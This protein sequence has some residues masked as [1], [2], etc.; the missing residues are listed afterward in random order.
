[1][2]SVKTL[3][4]KLLF[5][6]QRKLNVGEEDLIIWS[7]FRKLVV[8]LVGSD[9]PQFS[10]ELMSLVKDKDID[11]LLS[12]VATK[13][14]PHMHGSASSYWR[15]ATLASFLSKFPFRNVPN[16]DPMG[17]AKERS[18]QAERLCRLTNKRLSHYRGKEYRLIQKRRYV[19]E[20]LHLA[21]IKI[22]NWL[23]EASVGQVASKARHGPGGCLGV[24]RP[25]TTAYYKVAAERYT[26]TARC[27]PLVR[28]YFE[29]PENF[30]L[31]RA[32]SGLGPFDDGPPLSSDFILRERLEVTNYNKVTYVPKT[33]R[34]HRAIAVEPMLN[35]FFQLGVGRVL[36]SKMRDI[37]LD[38]DSSWE[39]NKQLA[40]LGSQL[41]DGTD[42]ALSTVDL[43]MASDTLAVELV[44]EL[45][46]PDWF[47]LLYDLR[48][49]NGLHGDREVP[50]AKFSSMGN[51][52]TFEL[53]TLIFY[54]LA[55]SLCQVLGVRGSKV[56]VFG[57]D[58][59]IPSSVFEPFTDL[60][61]FVG[62]RTNLEK[63]YHRGPFRESCGGDYF[64]GEDVRPFYLKRRL[65]QVRDLIFL[66]NNLRLHLKKGEALGLDPALRHSLVEY[67][68]SRMPQSIP[69][70]LLGPEE[71]PSDGVLF[72]DFDQAHKSRL[73]VWDRTVQEMSYPALREQARQYPGDPAIV[74]LQLIAGT[75]LA[76]ESYEYSW[77]RESESAEKL[78]SRAIVTKSRS[79][80]TR[81][82]S[83]FAFSWA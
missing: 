62:F 66:R 16:L 27:I 14:D 47:D 58:I 80:V 79:T 53:E 28:A 6:A 11:R 52:F 25:A 75:E 32:L 43:S 83:R 76:A 49:P 24:K 7:S 1:V 12:R 4:R 64:K 48:S 21:R 51:G 31:R 69:D 36:R 78:L 13:A 45:L 37:G 19:H 33:A 81:L 23:G 18:A 77:I 34:T 67:I 42:D 29:H 60:M 10:A 22:S 39:R 68:D 17:K 46:P 74:F 2:N 3:K 72:T 35:I 56:S 50:W 20:V 61:R 38:L 54:A 9:D 5:D 65:F 41:E 59:V 71:G 63:T 73:V 30:Q 82:H 26:V 44:R 57:D 8:G 40:L 15:Y 70:H 55:K